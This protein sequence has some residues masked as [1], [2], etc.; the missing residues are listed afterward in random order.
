LCSGAALLLNWGT[1]LLQLPA[2]P[3]KPFSC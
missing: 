3:R 2:S 1:D